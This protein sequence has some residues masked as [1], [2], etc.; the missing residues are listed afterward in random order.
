MVIYNN[1]HFLCEFTYKLCLQSNIIVE[2]QN[3]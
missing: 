3:T 2:I 1:L